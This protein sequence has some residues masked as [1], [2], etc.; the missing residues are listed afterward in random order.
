MMRARLVVLLDIPQRLSS[1]GSRVREN[2]QFLLN[3]ASS[4]MMA[5]TVDVA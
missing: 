2:A 4:T 1:P 3:S 5:D